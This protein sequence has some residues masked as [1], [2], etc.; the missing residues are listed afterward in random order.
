MPAVRYQPFKHC[1]HPTAETDFSKVSNSFWQVFPHEFIIAKIDPMWRWEYYPTENN[2]EAVNDK[3]NSAAKCWLEQV[4]PDVS[5]WLQE[6]N[7]ECMIRSSGDQLDPHKKNNWVPDNIKNLMLID[8][9]YS[10]SSWS[11]ATICMCNNDHAL[12]FKMEFC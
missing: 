6:N 12:L 11:V 8:S 1:Y 10:Y 2:C 4:M 9:I 3:L 5:S 7:T